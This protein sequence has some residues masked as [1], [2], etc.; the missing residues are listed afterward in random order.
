MDDDKP[1]D[2]EKNEDNKESISK[3][4]WPD[5]P[6]SVF[7]YGLIVG[8]ALI[9]LGGI[10]MAI[11]P[12]SWVV[13]VFIICTGLSIIFGAFG[14]R[15][16]ISV[17]GETGALLG[18]AAIAVIVFMVLIDQV[19]ERYVH[20]RIIGDV[21][22]K[23]VK[24]V[25]LAG[26][27]PYA[28]GMLRGQDSWD[29][30]IFGGQIKNSTLSLRIEPLG[31]AGEVY[32]ECIDVK[33]VSP[34]LASG[35]TL[36]WNYNKKD[37]RLMD[38][39]TKTIVAKVG[40]FEDGAFANRGQKKQIDTI[41]LISSA[42]AADNS[43]PPSP[44]AELIRELNSDSQYV[45]QSAR[46]S[47]GSQRTTVINPLLQTL[48]AG[49]ASY[50]SKLGALVALNKIGRNNRQ[51][52]LPAKAILSEENLAKILDIAN[53]PEKTMRVYASEFL[54]LLADPRTIGIALQKMPAAASDGRYNYILIIQSSLRE[55]DEAQRS[56]VFEKLPSLKDDGSD[57]TNK[58]IDSVM[59][60]PDS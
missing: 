55:A 16:K 40:C 23:Q 30:Y 27:Q 5:K 58:L 10:P 52:L 26:D 43:N 11:N 48:L 41:S 20:V 2:T 44:T 42:F 3:A 18:V 9:L 6:T 34:Y 1:T 38:V 37:D 45:R 13:E 51:D 15:A 46:E 59:L 19:S 32:F 47:L 31:D 49:D 22:A 33:K 39:A 12:F 21:K 14:S 57:K 53:D 24:T 25:E 4:D 35:K 29:F 50:R 54:Y 17:L 8:F 7:Q 60:E 56:L 28:G 36:T